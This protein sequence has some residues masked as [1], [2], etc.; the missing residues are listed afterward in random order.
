M[1]SI[2]GNIVNMN[3]VKRSRIEIDD[4]SGLITKVSEPT[5]SADFIFKD[6]LIFPGFIDLHVH[7]REDSSHTQDYKEDFKTAGEAAINGGVVAF[8]EM[9]NNPVPPIDDVSYEKKKEL[10]QE[11]PIEVVLYAGIGPDT[12]PLSKTVPYKAFM[13][14]S[15]GELFF[16]SQKELEET[17]KNYERQNISFH[18]EDSVILESSKGAPTHE[19]K[20]P[21]EAEISAVDFAL[22]LTKKY[23]LISKICHCSTIESIEKIINVKKQGVK[24]SVEVTPHHLFFDETML[25][26]KNHTLLQVN[27]P[28]RQSKENRLGLISALKNGDIDYLATDHAPHTVE[29]KKKG[30]S[31]MPHLDTY[32]SFVAWLMKEHSFTPG[33]VTRV[34]SQNPGNFINQFTQSKY[35]KIKEGYL[36]SLSILDLTRSVKITEDKLKTKC[37]WSPFLDMIFPGSVVM[38]VVRGKVYEK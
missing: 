17:I 19:N 35:G 4:I 12:K 21:K 8:A 9:P 31:G 10:T 20:R 6:E 18:C 30:M 36:G 1:I 34:C 13:G 28:I 2:E 26:E 29:E 5:G 7:A 3:G 37:K 23:N 24:V 33:E 16:H 15:V 22:Y 32:G 27:P 14:P 38:T 11:S 25:D